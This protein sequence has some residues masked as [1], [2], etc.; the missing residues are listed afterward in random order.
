MLKENQS[1]NIRLITLDAP[2]RHN[3][4]SFSLETAIK[5]AMARA[6]KDE[7][8]R[9]IILYG[10]KS[11]SFSA[12]GDFNEV[13]NLKGDTEIEEWI[14]RVIDLY[15]SVLNV[16]KPTI[17]AVDGYAI[18]MGFQFSLMFD[19]RI[20]S[21]TAEYI[22]PEL[23]HGIGCSVG[24]AILTHTHSFSIMQEIVYQCRNLNA[25]DCLSYGLVNGIVS[26]DTLLDKA[27]CIAKNMSE[28]PKSAFSNTKKAAN[29]SFI[30]MLEKT[31]AS[32]K[33]VHKAAFQSRDAQRHF[34]NILGHNY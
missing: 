11:R 3:P 9:A 10:G 22:M 33:S 30:E 29:K 34:E 8:V 23:R 26:S 15:L 21:S 19:Q 32:S 13:K 1:E 12:G 18:G 7:S 28:Y 2:N 25:Q 31:R 5:E 20:M 24:A 4:F 16:S 14:D 6:E 27:L 17:A